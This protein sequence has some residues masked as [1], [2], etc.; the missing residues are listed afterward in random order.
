MSSNMAIQSVLSF[1]FERAAINRTIVVTICTVN[2]ITVAIC[3]LY[4]TDFT[5][6]RTTVHSQN[7]PFQIVPILEARSSTTQNPSPLPPP[8]I[9]T[10]FPPIRRESSLPTDK[11][12]SSCLVSVRT[13]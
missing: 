5:R 11:G 2:S 6:K 7:M 3:E 10:L 4:S 1:L 13:D 9:A 12:L 8:G